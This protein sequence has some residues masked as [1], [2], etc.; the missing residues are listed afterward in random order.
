MGDLKRKFR[1]WGW[2]TLIAV[3][4][5]S[6]Y[7]GGGSNAFSGTT[8][9]TSNA[10]SIPAVT[11][12][13]SGNLFTIENNNSYPIWLGEYV[14][15][16]TKV[17]APAQGWEMDAGSTVNLCTTPPWTSGRFWARTE[18]DFT[19][20]YQSTGS[21]GSGPL[22]TCSADTDCN[23]L[24][25]ATGLSYDCIG[26]ACVVDC[27]SQP[28][29]QAAAYCIS[30]IGPAVNK[31]SG[32]N[33][34]ICSNNDPW[35]KSYCTYNAG[36]VCKTGDCGGLYQ[37]V[38][39]YTNGGTSNNQIVAGSPPATLFEPTSDSLSSVNYDVSNVGGS[40]LRYRSRCRRSLRSARPI[41]TIATNRPA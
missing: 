11:T 16:P 25:T 10:H 40:R 31:P 15:D 36:V 19:D 37:C 5:V 35:G 18:C 3:A 33:A 21:S 22:T 26:G 6:G 12:C 32:N 4:M 23:S 39:T 41:Q 24:A 30:H 20:L 1:W 27:S 7:D 29:A 28:V 2:L 38:G 34:A 9:G 14:G 13:S 8:S 17:V